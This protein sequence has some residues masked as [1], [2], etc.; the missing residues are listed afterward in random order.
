[1][2]ANELLVYLKDLTNAHR[3]AEL[4]CSTHYH[5]HEKKIKKNPSS[6]SLTKITVNVSSNKHNNNN[7]HQ[8]AKSQSSSAL[9]AESKN[10]IVSTSDENFLNPNYLAQAKNLANIKYQFSFT[11]SILGDELTS[12][13]EFKVTYSS[14]LFFESY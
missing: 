7:A 11:G 4:I 12:S 5:H 2:L 6:N 1:M 10:K 3:F 14:L 13:S 8:H 9:N